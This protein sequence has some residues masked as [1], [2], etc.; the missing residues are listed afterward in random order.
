MAKQK[1]TDVLDAEALEELEELGEE[2]ED[3]DE[4]ENDSTVTPTMLAK[5]LGINPKALRAFLRKTFPRSA[6]EKNTSWHLTPA[7]IE[8]AEDHFLEDEDDES[9]DV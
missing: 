2:L 3:G 5:T 6:A 1:A 8:A 9:D 4:E 7:M